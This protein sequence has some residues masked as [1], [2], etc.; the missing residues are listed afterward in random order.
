[1]FHLPAGPEL[2]VILVI[3]LIVFGP[4]KLPEIGKS[5]GQGLRE[6]KKASREI[7]DAFQNIDED[8][9][10]SYSSK[11]SLPTTTT[12]PDEHI[13]NREPAQVTKE[14]TQ[15]ADNSEHHGG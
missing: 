11:S 6:L 3:A 7:T 1:M 2:I 10:P 9:E 8:D 14:I 13:E 5:I 12:L 15:N 4:K